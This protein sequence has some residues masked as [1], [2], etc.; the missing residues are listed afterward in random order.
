M[1]RSRILPAG[2]AFACAAG[3]ASCSLAPA[4]TPPATPT[5]T[6]YRETGPWI[7]ATPADAATRGA[8]WT[9]FGSARLNALEQQL[10]RLN[11]TFA[12]ALR[13]Y[14]QARGYLTI[15][16][17]NGL[18][19][20]DAAAVGSDNRQSDNR[21]LR[22][23]KQPNQYAANTI[24]DVASYELDLWGRVR[25]SVAA[26]KADLQAGAA[27]LASLKLSLQATLAASYARLRQLDAQSD[28]LARAV[29]SYQRAL[30]LTRHRFDG[31][32]ASRVD[33]E[34]ATTQLEATRAQ[35]A[36][37]AA[38]RALVEHAI[39][40]L[41]GANSSEFAIPAEIEALHI[42]SVPTG[43]P[44]DLL[45][46]RPDIAAGE[47]RVSAAN[48]RIGVARAAFFPSI[49]LV[50]TSGYQ[51]T[52]QADLL[53]AP[54][55]FWSIGPAAAVT[56]FDGGRRSAGVKIARAAKQEAVETYRGLVLQAF[57]EVEDSLAMLNH[58]A[59][60]SDAQDAA[61]AAAARAESLSLTRY[62]K[63]AVTYLEVVTAQAS[64]LQAERTQID[65]NE[66]RIEA[67]VKLIRALGGGWSEA[68]HGG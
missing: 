9:A 50:G 2:L 27:D 21:P 33:L 20:V 31:G 64:A 36:D 14:D 8:W 63:G 17:A 30:D 5:P 56:L 25:N 1:S 26:G 68:E 11:P 29:V 12:A 37:V 58:Y 35:V 53:S 61:V 19:R 13:R 6:R 15:A 66:R 22:G 62:Q 38:Q 46:R 39:A 49:A 3:L 57:Q 32:V 23:S 51:N 7:L 34:R 45:Q 67:S 59:E 28:L 54:N 4:Y 52:G 24:G 42:P 65:L 41:V 40:S 55:T 48:D 18:P 47:R 10:D 16:A 43:V 60:E 44:S